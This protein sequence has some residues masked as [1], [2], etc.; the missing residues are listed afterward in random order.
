MC[1]FSLINAKFVY[2]EKVGWIFGE[3]KN[4]ID[5]PNSLWLIAKRLPMKRRFHSGRNG[6]AHLNGNAQ[7]KN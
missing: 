4:T 3:E 7:Q 6:N 1:W 5:V 2:H